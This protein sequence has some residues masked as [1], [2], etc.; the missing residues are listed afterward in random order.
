MV[1][2][3]Q[4]TQVTVVMEWRMATALE[5]RSAHQGQVERTWWVRRQEWAHQAW[6]QER[7]QRMAQIRVERARLREQGE[8]LGSRDSIMA[9]ELEVELAER[10][11]LRRWRPLPAG[12]EQIPGRP[13]GRTNLA[14]R[15]EVRVALKLPSPLVETVRRACY[16]TSRPAVARVMAGDREAAAGVVTTG[17][18]LR[19][20]AWRAAQGYWPP[21]KEREA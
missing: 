1:S 4:R 14:E 6:G 15:G 18:V 7:R 16:W 10:G 5:A 2:K 20:A 12:A 8:L 11:W 13:W 9:T 17:D 19:S 3:Q 21:P